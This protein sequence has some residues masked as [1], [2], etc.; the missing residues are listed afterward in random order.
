MIAKHAGNMKNSSFVSTPSSSAH[1]I[2][3]MI[4]TRKPLEVDIVCFIHHI[5]S[6][7][8]AIIQPFLQ[9]FWEG[10]QN[11]LFSRSPA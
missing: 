7:N 10:S 5:N 2:T 1:Q 6:T 3:V 11:I 9:E 8:F 4:S